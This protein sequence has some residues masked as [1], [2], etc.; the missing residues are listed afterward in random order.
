[1]FLTLSLITLAD[2][3]NCCYISDLRP[4]DDDSCRKVLSPIKGSRPTETRA[5]LHSY[6]KARM[7]PIVIPD[8][9]RKIDMSKDEVNFW[10]TSQSSLM[11]TESLPEE[12]YL[13]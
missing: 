2:D 7:S 6:R 12:C 5:V 9:M 4:A 11:T 8:N 3:S 1:M 13:F 10:M